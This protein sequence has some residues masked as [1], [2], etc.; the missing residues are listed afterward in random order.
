LTK[1]GNLLFNATAFWPS[2]GGKLGYINSE[3]SP[4]DIESMF[5]KMVDDPEAGQ[6]RDPGAVYVSDFIKFAD[7][8]RYLEGFTQ[9]F[10]WSLTTKTI[11]EPDNIEE[12]K[13]KF[14]QAI[15]DA[16]GAVEALG[17]IKDE[18]EEEAK[19]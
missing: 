18:Q 8:I 7:G 10:C 3:E 13:R 16:T 12:V 9:V 1:A 19:A 5:V 17:R 14:Q 2:V 6:E 15:D 11:T 4:S